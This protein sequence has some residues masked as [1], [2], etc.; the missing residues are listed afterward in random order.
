MPAYGLGTYGLGVYGIGETDGG[1][2]TVPGHALAVALPTVPIRPYKTAAYLVY[3]PAGVPLGWWADA[4][5]PEFRAGLDGIDGLTLDLPR[6]YGGLD[7]PGEPG[8]GGTLAHG[9]TIEVWIID[10]LRLRSAATSGGS[11]VGSGAVGSM[12][13][14]QAGSIGTLV[15][16]GTLEDYEITP[17]TGVRLQCLPLSRILQQTK[18]P[19]TLS[20]SGDPVALARDTVIS[21]LPGLKWD[22]TNPDA[23]GDLVGPLTFENPTAGDVLERL[24]DLAGVGWMLHVTPRGSVRFLEPETQGTEHQLIAG[25]HAIEPRLHKDGRNRAK[26]VTV[27]YADGGVTTAYA[28]DYDP[29]DP[30]GLSVSANHLEAGDAAMLAAL[31]LRARDRVTLRGSCTVLSE[32]YDLESLNVGDTVRLVV[33]RPGDV[34]G[35]VGGAAIVGKAIVGQSAVATSGYLDYNTSLVLAGYQYG[36][37]RAALELSAPQPDVQ[38]QIGK[39]MRDVARIGG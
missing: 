13:V 28:A 12:A 29:N 19:G 22:I 4:P 6:P 18:I 17:P 23:S 37:H 31:T 10:P 20:M 36:T 9:N 7:E 26:A 34:T 11:G 1:E 38:R 27:T 33:E 30:R 5:L 15:W 24:R 32:A 35:G 3:S 21:Y 2:P 14:G 16:K 8:S 25:I 39:L